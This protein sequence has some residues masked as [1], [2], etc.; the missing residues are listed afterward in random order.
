MVDREK[1]SYNNLIP[2]QMKAK[3]NGSKNVKRVWI[4]EYVS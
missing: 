4:I 2:C 3:H 1:E